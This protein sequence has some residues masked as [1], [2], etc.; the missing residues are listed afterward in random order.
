[1]ILSSLSCHRRTPSTSS[2][3]SA[4]SDAWSLASSVANKTD[5][6]TPS[7]TLRRISNAD[8]RAADTLLLAKAIANLQMRT[9]E[10][11]AR[12]H[13][14]LRFWLHLDQAQS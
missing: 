3:H 5:E 11:V 12:D 4:R 7:S 9:I 1:M 8:Q 6:K 14:S 13:P 10:E 2:W